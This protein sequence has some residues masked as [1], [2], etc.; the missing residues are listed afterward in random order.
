MAK[1]KARP[2]SKTKRGNTMTSTKIYKDCKLKAVYFKDGAFAAATGVIT[3]IDATI[4]NIEA[5][6]QPDG[7][8]YCESNIEGFIVPH[9]NV[10]NAVFTKSFIEQAS[11]KKETEKKAKTT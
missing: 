5:Y 4:K 3:K 11:D 2:C 8:I 6:Y 9:S 10:K 1:R 7:N